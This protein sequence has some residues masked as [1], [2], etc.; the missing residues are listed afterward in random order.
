MLRCSKHVLVR[1]C[2]LNTS[3][4]GSIPEPGSLCFTNGNSNMS[5]AFIHS[6]PVHA[7]VEP[8]L[9]HKKHRSITSGGVCTG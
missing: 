7:G 9:L 2:L 6:S 5:D 3:A 1:T 8:H 4:L